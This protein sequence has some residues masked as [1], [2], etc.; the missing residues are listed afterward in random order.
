VSRRAV[1]TDRAHGRADLDG[2]APS[3]GAGAGDVDRQARRALE[4]RGLDA[5][6]AGESPGAVDDH[7]HTEALALLAGQGVDGAVL[8]AHHLRLLRFEAHV[9]VGRAEPVRQVEHALAVVAHEAS[10]S[11]A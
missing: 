11:L 5:R 6:A 1:A 3:E 8:H 9:G 4:L 7:A 2:P 10:P